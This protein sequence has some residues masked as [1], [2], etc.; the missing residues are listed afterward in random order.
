MS[1]FSK[2]S[3]PLLQDR[4]KKLRRTIFA[5]GIVSLAAYVTLF[6]FTEKRILSYSN[7]MMEAARIMEQATSIIRDYCKQSG[8]EIDSSIDPNQTGLVGPEYTELTTIETTP[9]FKLPG[10]CSLAQTDTISSEM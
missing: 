4:D 5:A 6:I 7:E 2:R 10:T 9:T 3:A 1:I 8:I